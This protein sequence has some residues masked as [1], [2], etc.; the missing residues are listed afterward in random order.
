MSRRRILSMEAYVIKI[1]NLPFFSGEKTDM[2][3][4]SVTCVLL[5]ENIFFEH[6]WKAEASV[7]ISYKFQRVRVIY[8]EPPNF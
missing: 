3:I 8:K 4:G 2:L 1:E 7:I 6:H 5:D